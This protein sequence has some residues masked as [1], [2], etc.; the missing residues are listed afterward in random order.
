MLDRLKHSAAKFMGPPGKVYNI[1]TLSMD[2]HPY[3]VITH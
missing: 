1:L 3:T 2:F